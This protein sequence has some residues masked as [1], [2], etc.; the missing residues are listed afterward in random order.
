MAT[1]NLGAAAFVYK[2]NWAL[3]GGTGG[4]GAY[5]RMHVVRNNNSIWVAIVETEE[6]PT[7]TSSEWAL[8]LENADEQAVIAL[9]SPSVSTVAIA[10]IT[11]VSA[12]VDV[13]VQKFGFTVSPMVGVEYR[14]QGQTAWLRTST[15]AATTLGNISI[16]MS[17]LD[18]ETVYEARGFVIDPKNPDILSVGDILL[19][20]TTSAFIAIPIVS[21]SGYPDSI[22]TTPTLSTSAFSAVGLA[23]THLA[24]TWRAKQGG[25]VVWEAVG[26]TVNLTSIDIPSGYLEPNIEYT[27]EAIHI[28]QTLGA[29][30][31]GSISATTANTL[32]VE[33]L[34]V[35]GGGNTTAIDT[36]DGGNS[37]V[38]S[39]GASGGEVLQGTE[40]ILI[41]STSTI[42]IGASAS[43]SSA[44]GHTA[45]AG[46]STSTVVPYSSESPGVK[47]WNGSSASNGG[48][49]HYAAGDAGQDGVAWL[50]G[51]KY[52]PGGGGASNTAAGAGGAV[53]GGRGVMTYTNP[54]P[55]QNGAP[56]TGAG[57]GGV[58]AG[59]YSGNRYAYGGTG[60]F[61]FRYPGST[62]RHTGGTHTVSGG[63]VWVTFTTSGTLTITG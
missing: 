31:V 32:L 63:Y 47:G 9:F 29:S 12:S 46:N 8:M 55:A 51:V 39:G 19:F 5:K 16:P 18:L 40:H 37:N 41:G 61:K 53:G 27:F 33:F 54:T 21:V 57:A 13:D 43:S 4:N 45:R 48:D 11:G 26:D 6:E 36:G 2:G 23:D 14:E 3:G 22:S 15:I 60:V 17:G 56:N 35:G 25:T 42:V 38:Q 24:T 1:A 49:A 10:N 34:L 7:S 58:W 62:V 30:A 28:G 20:S 44:F 59:T 52:A 50:D